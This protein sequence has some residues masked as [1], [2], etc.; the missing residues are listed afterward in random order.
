MDRSQRRGLV[1]NA[2]RAAVGLTDDSAS[3][4]PVPSGESNESHPLR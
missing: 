4:H 2:K 1:A 3:M